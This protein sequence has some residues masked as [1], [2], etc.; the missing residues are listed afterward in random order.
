MADLF[1]F[2]DASTKMANGKKAYVL[3]SGSNLFP[4]KER[5]ENLSTDIAFYRSGEPLSLT[6]T[7]PCPDTRRVLYDE[8][9]QHYY[10]EV[11]IYL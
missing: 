3:D 11:Y 7:L 10:V 8:Q 2:N 1:K 9:A 5:C 6:L 4:L